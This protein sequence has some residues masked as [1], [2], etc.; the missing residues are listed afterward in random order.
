MDAGTPESAAL[1]SPYLRPYGVPGDHAFFSGAVVG[2]GTHSVCA[3]GVSYVTGRN[4][5][6][7][8][9]SITLR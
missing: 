7:K 3:V 1:P 2:R 6:L 8:C 9:E 5:I 4:A